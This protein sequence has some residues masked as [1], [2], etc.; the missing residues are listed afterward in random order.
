M[1]SGFIEI[2]NALHD[3]QVEFVIVSGGIGTHRAGVLDSLF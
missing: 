2:L 1:K 3:R